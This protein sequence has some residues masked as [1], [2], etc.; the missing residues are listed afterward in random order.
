M[1]PAGY[2][3]V[4]TGPA[5]RATAAGRRLSIEPALV[6]RLLADTA[7]S[8]DALP[9]LA[10]TLA[11]AVS[12]LRRTTEISRPKS[13]S[14]RRSVA[15]AQVVQTEVDT[16]LGADPEQRQA[17]LELLHDAFI[18]WLATINPGNDQPMRRLARC[19]D[20]PA[21]SRPLIQ[22][23]VEKRLLVKDTRDGQ[24]VVEVALESLLRQWREL[25]TWL[26]DETQ[27]LKA[28]DTLERAATDW[29]T[30][31]RDESWL[32]AGTRLADAETL[33]A[34]PRFRDRLDPTRDYLPRLPATPRK[35][36]H[37]SAAETLPDPRCAAGGHRHRR[38][39]GGGSGR[40]GQPRA[41]QQADARF[42]EAT[43]LRLVAEAQPMLAGAR[44]G[45]AVRAYQQL[46]A[47]RRLAQTPDDGPL[48]NALVK[49]VNLIKIADAGSPVSS[50][51]FSP[52]GTRIASGSDDKTVR[53]WDAATGQPVGAP[54][55]RPHRR[56]V[57][58]WRSAPTA[59]ASPPA[60]TT[61]RCGCGTRPPANRSAPR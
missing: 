16:L 32:L 9:L 12:R 59:P 37:R 50:V 6:E 28:A 54:A 3:E 58:A 46:L 2:T 45:G 29:Q 11:A 60:A 41:D 17:R 40:T 10:L 8:A 57:P 55:H 4:I 51:A 34:K 22:A 35:R 38:R 19:D 53:L 33:A 20:L 61:R 18:P 5:R 30:S 43:S 56:G 25:A 44:S 7:E 49:T 39:R 26:R 14:T 23:M 13:T 24:V 36:P 42:R 31:G 21:A 48:V 52:D 1:P 47:A 27:D 15:C